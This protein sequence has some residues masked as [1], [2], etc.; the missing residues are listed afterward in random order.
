MLKHFS[1]EEV[2]RIARKV[3][4]VQREGK[5]KA[6]KFLY[7]CAFSQ[8]DVSKDTLVTMS[9]NLSSKTKTTV[10]SQALD[11]RLNEKAVKFLKE[12]FTRLLNSV[13]L[14]N[15][16][17]PTIWDEHFNRI[18][19]VD[20]TAFQ[21]SEIYKS[22]YPGSGGSSQPSGI[23]IQLEYELKSGNFMH[24]DVGPGSGND[25]TFGSKIKD[26]FKAGDLSLRDLGYFNFKDFEDMENKK[27]FYVSRL[28]PNI[29]VYVK[30]ENVEYLKNGQP[31]KSSVYKRLFLKDV[32]SVQGFLLLI[33]Q[34]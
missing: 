20:S 4:F 32:T 14:T 3:G 17:I 6:W 11:Q 30:N 9:A 13:P 31:R 5:L 29:A 34:L 8:L 19:I 21:V 1:K 25:N 33:P 12:I 27:S 28:K 10:S 26:T 7:L 22:V 23:K 15:S 24:I 2:E 16:N 18:R